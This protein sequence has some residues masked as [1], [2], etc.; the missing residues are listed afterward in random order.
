[1]SLHSGSLTESE[2]MANADDENT[3]KPGTLWSRLRWL[4][5]GELHRVPVDM[6]VWA[7][8]DLQSWAGSTIGRSGEV[9]DSLFGSR[10]QTNGREPGFQSAIRRST[11]QVWVA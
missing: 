2:D 10:S 4:S 11:A 9:V 6:T 1:M 3:S 8:P 5:H 7:R